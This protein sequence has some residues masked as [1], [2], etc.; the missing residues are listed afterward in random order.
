MRYCGEVEEETKE[1]PKTS[2]EYTDIDGIRILK[3]GCKGK[4]VEAMQAILIEKGYSCGNSMADGDF[5]ANTEK[6]IINF[7][8]DK[9]IDCTG[10]C[11][12]KT[13]KQLI[14]G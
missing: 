6:A 8:T 12:S 10:I 5:G 3:K 7:Q 11:D 13:W 4:D 1:P 14:I 9:G 2:D